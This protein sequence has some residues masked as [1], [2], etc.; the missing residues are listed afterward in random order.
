MNRLNELK[1]YYYQCEK[2]KLVDNFGKLVSELVSA[3]SL[4]NDTSL[5]GEQ[6]EQLLKNFLDQLIEVWHSEVK[7]RK[8]GF[9]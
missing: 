3:E 5:N 2:A 6:I 7:K 8:S 1:K 9:V 4:P